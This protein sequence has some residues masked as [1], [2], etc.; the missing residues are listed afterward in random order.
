MKKLVK[1]MISSTSD[2]LES[3][4]RTAIEVCDCLDGIE[5]IPMERFGPESCKSID[6]CLRKVE[7]ADIYLGIIAHRYG[8]IPEGED[9]S[10]TEMEYDH[11]MSLGKPVFIF[12]VDERVPWFPH[13]MDHGVLKEK[14]ENF[15][16]KLRK[17]HAIEKF[18]NSQNSRDQLLIL[19]PQW[20]DK[21]LK[22]EVEEED[23]YHIPTPPDPYVSLPPIPQTKMVS[24]RNELDLLTDWLRNPDGELSKIRVLNIVAMGGMGKSTLTW[25]WFDEIVPREAKSLAGRVWW[26]FYQRALTSK[27][28]HRRAGIR[29]KAAQKYYQDNANA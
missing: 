12:M 7:E 6:L 19:L 26:S 21:L 15:K 29:L 28:R 3:C 5:S 25:E 11:A 27:I 8:S 9:R 20:R 2:D 17:N 10:F 24:R 4:R 23:L 18:S 22:P 14:L 13:L 1:V 16:A